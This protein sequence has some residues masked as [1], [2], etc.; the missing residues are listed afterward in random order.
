MKSADAFP[1]GADP[2]RPGPGSLS[3]RVPHTRARRDPAGSR[4]GVAGGGPARA[5]PGVAGRGRRPGWWERRRGEGRAVRPGPGRGVRGGVGGAGIPVDRARRRHG[6][7]AGPGGVG[8]AAGPVGRVRD[9][10]RRGSGR[11][12]AAGRPAHARSAAGGEVA[13]PPARNDRCW[14]GSAAEYEKCC[15]RP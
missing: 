11:V 1:C 12:G 8:S 6:S 9:H 14:C 5:R 10:L 4:R 13:W 7:T 3:R 2:R 15:G